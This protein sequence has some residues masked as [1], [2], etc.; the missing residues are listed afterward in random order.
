M[1]DWMGIVLFSF[2]AI[3]MGM[4]IFFWAIALTG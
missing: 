4:T 1:C 3:A 2:A